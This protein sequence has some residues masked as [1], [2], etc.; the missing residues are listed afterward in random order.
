ME[1]KFTQSLISILSHSL[2]YCLVSDWT[3]SFTY[4]SDSLTSPRLSVTDSII[5]SVTLTD[6]LSVSEWVTLTTTYRVSY[7]PFYGEVYLM[8]LHRFAQT[9]IPFTYPSIKF[10]HTH[11]RGNLLPSLFLKKR[12]CGKPFRFTVYNKFNQQERFPL[13]GRMRGEL[14]GNLQLYSTVYR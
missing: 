5:H 4:L 1:I 2:T 13:S 3:D 8:V 6:P 7:L 12:Q 9:R 10:G 14:I 11:L